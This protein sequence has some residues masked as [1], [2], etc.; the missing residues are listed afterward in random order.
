MLTNKTKA[1]SLF[2]ILDALFE[3]EFL[4]GNREYELSKEKTR[5]LIQRIITNEN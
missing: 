4:L 2:N 5:L 1:D 3:I